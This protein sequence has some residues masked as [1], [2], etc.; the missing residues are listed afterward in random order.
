MHGEGLAAEVDSPALARFL[1]ADE[2]TI[3]R[4]LQRLHQEGY[5][6]S[7]GRAYRLSRT[8]LQEGGRSFRDEFG[9]YIHPAHAECGPGCWCRDPK[10]AGEACP[11]TVASAAGSR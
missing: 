11:S 10:H 3:T 9:D 6:E 2:S 4:H 5:L 8:G 7:H 1:A